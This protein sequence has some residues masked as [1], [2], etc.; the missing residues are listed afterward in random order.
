MMDAPAPAGTPQA[1]VVAASPPIGSLGRELSRIQTR[2]QL[3]ALGLAV[4]VGLAG[5]FLL[6]RAVEEGAARN[7][8][9]IL[10][11]WLGAGICVLA[12]LTAC[13]VVAY[14]P[15]FLMRGLDRKAS[16]AHAWLGAREV[17]RLFGS[18]A[19]AFSIPT[20]PESAEIW[21]ATTP[22]TTQMRPLRF[23]LLLMTRHWDEAREL[24]QRFPRQTPLDEFRVAEAEA[25][26]ADQSTGVAD[27][28]A[29]REAAARVPAGVDLAEA[30]A[31]VGVFEARRLIGRGDWRV[32]LAEARPLIPESDATIIFRD[33]AAPIFRKIWPFFVLPVAAIAVVIALVVTVSVIG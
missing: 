23:E 22:D 16:V 14:L 21:L 1:S 17:R 11:I 7:G 3:A 26:V 19:G 18:T 24:I 10:W 8:G 29:M 20:S 25:L 12:M 32:P 28:A 33:L 30:M 2:P 6:L 9:P 15:P 13:A 4:I 5:P 27:G 31:S